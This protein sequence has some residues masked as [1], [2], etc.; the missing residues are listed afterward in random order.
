MSLRRLSCDT[1]TTNGWRRAALV[2]SLITLAPPTGCSMFQPD[3]PARPQRSEGSRR[4]LCDNLKQAATM[5]TI[6]AVAS[7]IASIAVLAQPC[8]SRTVSGPGLLG[9]TSTRT[10]LDCLHRL[11]LIPVGTMTLGYGASAASGHG[12][13]SRCEAEAGT[14]DHTSQLAL[15]PAGTAKAAP[16]GES[17]ARLAVVQVGGVDVRSAPHAIA[18]VLLHL[19]LGDRLLVSATARDGWRQVRLFDG[20]FGYVEDARVKIADPPPT[21]LSI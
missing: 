5:D 17:G 7:A 4:R 10:D 13:A 6:V 20:R 1:T 18:P 8:E 2:V 9:G 16:S 14:L 19:R 11:L 21:P 15:E 3:A 12:R